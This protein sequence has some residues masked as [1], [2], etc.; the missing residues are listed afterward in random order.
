MPGQ[1]NMAGG[2][3]AESRAA[4]SRA[5]GW[6]A[7]PRSTL[8]SAAR[9]SQFVRF[10]KRF[11]PLV[12]TAVA[13]AVI[14]YALQPRDQ[15]NVAMTFERMGTIEDDLAMIN[16]RLTGTD[17]NG[18]PFVITAASAV[19]DKTD[20]QRARLKSLQADL[21]LKDGAWITISA[22]EGVFDGR[23]RTVVLAGGINVFSDLGYEVH[24]ERAR[25]DLSASIVTGDAAVSA[26]GPMGTL[27]AE[28]FEI[29]HEV[30][31]VRF[32]GGVKMVLYS[33]EGGALP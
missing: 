27:T 10:M 29:R 31:E 12:A 7:A 15:H 3:A 28:G 25:V 23:G 8:S 16:P 20:P 18:L 17:E 30:R 1:P 13:A 9:Y 2:R 19:Q 4:R 11:L 32:T 26:Q 22:G 21:T 24:T 6:G 14:A 5:V 33:A